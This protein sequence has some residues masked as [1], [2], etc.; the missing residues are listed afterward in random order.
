MQHDAATN[1]YHVGGGFLPRRLVEL[2]LLMARQ[3]RRSAENG[4]S[5]NL[6]AVTSSQSKVYFK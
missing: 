2:Y 1:I 5:P 6:Q 3:A 4:P